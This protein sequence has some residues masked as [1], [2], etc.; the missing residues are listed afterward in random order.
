[1]QG[2]RMVGGCQRLHA[3]SQEP[4]LDI[5]QRHA[6][7]FR[8]ETL[9]HGKPDTARGTCHQSDLLRGRGHKCSFA[10]DCRVVSST[11]GGCLLF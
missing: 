6:P 3:L 8:K 1:M 2:E 5:E 11:E 10:I 9:C 4:A 7:A